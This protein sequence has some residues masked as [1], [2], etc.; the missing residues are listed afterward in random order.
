MLYEMLAGTRLLAAAAAAGPPTMG[1]RSGAEAGV[2]NS[3][4]VAW[5]GLSEELVR[6]SRGARRGKLP[7]AGPGP[8]G[9]REP[10]RGGV[11]HNVAEI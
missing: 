6:V 10:R 4:A 2:S 8:R 9:A 1:A 11:Y 5:D 7:G 3:G